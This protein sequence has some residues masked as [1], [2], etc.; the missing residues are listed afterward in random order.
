MLGKS[1][2]KSN[3]AGVDGVLSSEKGNEVSSKTT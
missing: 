1:S 3:V 2:R